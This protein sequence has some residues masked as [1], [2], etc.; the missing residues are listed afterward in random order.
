MKKMLFLL[1]MVFGFLACDNNV[2]AGHYGKSQIKAVTFNTKLEQDSDFKL[3]AERKAVILQKLTEGAE[4]II[5][6]QEV[7]DA[8]DMKKVHEAMNKA[9]DDFYLLYSTTGETGGGGEPTEPACTNEEVLPI[10]MCYEQKCQDQTGTGAL[11][12]L[13]QQCGT[14]FQNLSPECRNC[15]LAEGQNGNLDLQ[16]IM[17]ACM[18]T[19]NAS[20]EEDLGTNGLMLISRYPMK[21]KAITALP[22]DKTPRQYIS[23]TL[24]TQGALGDIDI[25][26]TQLSNSN[27]GDKADTLRSQQMAQII[28]WKNA[29]KST[30]WEWNVI[31]L[32]ETGHN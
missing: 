19:E 13:A 26:C 24:K 14:E 10:G 28:K 16:A 1:L 6:L 7:W 17:E 4:D 25:V 8:K 21:D 9:E 32:L 12:C 15:M 2:D 18:Q 31:M 20:P 29:A 22:S 23:A 27:D 3:N 11:L 30:D 5:C